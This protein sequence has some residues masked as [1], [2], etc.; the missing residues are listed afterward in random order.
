MWRFLSRLQTEQPLLLFLALGA[1]LFVAD[2][3]LRGA[4]GARDPGAPVLEIRG[5]RARRLLERHPDAAR[6]PPAPEAL[7][8]ALGDWI[9]EEVLVREARA[10][11]L[12][13]GD[14]IVRR[15]LAQK[16]RAILEQLHPAPEPDDAALRAA[17]A[18]DPERY[19]H[20]ATFDFEHVFLSRGRHGAALETA[21]TDLLARLRGGADFRTLGDPAPTGPVVS[22]ATSESVSR[23]Y[24]GAF[25]AKLATLPLGAW[26]GPVASSLGAHLV[27]VT[28]REPFREASVDGVREALLRDL[29]AAGREAANRA[30]LDA[31]IA[32]HALEIDADAAEDGE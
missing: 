28:A 2:A 10:I 31:L 16:M 27:R 22:G 19:G 32:R 18:A 26:H 13:E 30:A 29:R 24:G 23:R 8:A 4:D 9:E 14:V 11:G 15:R 25:A 12:E 6:R 3:A 20:P 5:E 21:A 17:L 7:R 1:A